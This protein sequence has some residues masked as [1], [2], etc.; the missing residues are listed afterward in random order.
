MSMH[1]SIGGGIISDGDLSLE[2]FGRNFDE[3]TSTEEVF[4]LMKQEIEDAKGY[5]VYKSEVLYKIMMGGNEDFTDEQMDRICT[6]IFT[7][8]IRRRLITDFNNNTL[9]L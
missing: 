6:M 7:D 8:E 1:G 3:T 9:R 4:S 5:R 2:R